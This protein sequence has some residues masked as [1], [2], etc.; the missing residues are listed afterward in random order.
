MQSKPRVGVDVDGVLADL[1]TPLFQH[2]NA[3]LGTAY[4]PD[5]MKDW[6]VAELIPEARRDE[7]WQTFGR[8]VRVHDA[9]QPCPGAIEGM[10]LLG[11]V[12]DVY[13][14]TAYLHSAPTWVHDRDKWLSD[15]FGISDKKIVHTHAKYTFFG[16]ALV[17]DKPS[18]VEAWSREHSRGTGVL[19]DQPY[20]RATPTRLTLWSTPEMWHGEIGDRH[21][22]ISTR[23]SDWGSL[24]QIL[25]EE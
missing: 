4:V 3:M 23:T 5:H 7:F 17:D 14:V 22:L 11:E 18:T 1:L 9:L 15:R 2:M 21:A 12:A 8:D 6:D 16:K 19:W 24:C 20:N 10:S 25:R 13:I